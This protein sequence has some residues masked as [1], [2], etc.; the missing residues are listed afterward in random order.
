MPR[1]DFLGSLNAGG[2][3]FQPRTATGNQ[4]EQVPL[5]ARP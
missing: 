1:G 3:S 5:D 4:S 2:D